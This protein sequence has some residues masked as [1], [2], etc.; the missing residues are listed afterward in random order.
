MRFLDIM[1]K[2]LNEISK[3][4]KKKFIYLGL[5]KKKLK[6]LQINLERYIKVI[7]Y[8]IYL[9]YIQPTKNINKIDET[10]VIKSTIYIS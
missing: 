10:K 6:E 2:L 4:L 8:I 3:I 7:S 9:Y 5:E 1:A